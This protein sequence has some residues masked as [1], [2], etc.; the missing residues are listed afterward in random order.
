[1][2]ITIICCAFPGILLVFSPS[3]WQIVQFLPAWV[4]L[5]FSIWDH[6]I[7]T[8]RFGFARHFG[9]TAK[10]LGLM[11]FGFLAFR[12]V[13]GAVTGI[14][15]YLILYMLSGVCIMRIIREEGKLTAGRNI[16]VLITLL[17]GSAA[18]ALLQM[19]QL[20]LNAAGF[21]YQNIIAHVIIGVAYVIAA[22]FYG[23]FRVLGRF[24]NIRG[25]DE[26]AAQEIYADW[27]V[28]E[29]LGEDTEIIL[30]G[31]PAWLEVAITVLLVLAVALVV[32]LIMRRLL[33]SKGPGSKTV[34]YT[35]ER[36]K[37]QEHGKGRRSGLLRPKDPRQAVR[38]Y[39]C[40]FLKE[41]LSRGARLSPDD[42]SHS[43]ALKCDTL[44]PKAGTIR[45]RDIYINAR[46]R[47]YGEITRED[48]DEAAKTWREM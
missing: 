22:V 35:E 48:A 2:P 40:K 7:Y 9:F 4:Y 32:F 31:V 44:F 1:M 16:T 27:D 17:L 28:Q 25:A 18:L 34:F 19:P 12:R 30:R 21:I 10:L 47:Y 3:L 37:L 20:I 24:I 46:Y 6:R 29:A 26:N 36:E 41:G 39:Y 5:A 15:P 33:G 13:E 42:T 14:V 45:L 38:W 8:S 23:I 11:A 43:V